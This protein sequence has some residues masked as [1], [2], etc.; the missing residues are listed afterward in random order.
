[1]SLSVVVACLKPVRSS[2]GSCDFFRMAPRVYK[3]P[4]AVAIESVR[5]QPAVVTA[6]ISTDPYNL[7][8]YASRTQAAPW[9][10][11]P[12]VE[13]S[14]TLT[15]E[16]LVHMGPTLAREVLESQR[17]YNLTRRRENID[18]K[19]TGTKSIIRQ[20]ARIMNIGLGKQVVDESDSTK[21]VWCHKGKT[22]LIEEIVQAVKNASEEA[23]GAVYRDSAQRAGLHF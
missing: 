11:Q 23:E 2:F 19:K 22:E 4:A 9:P 1:M 18:V 6:T 8:G 3:R 13:V 10:S 12:I 17:R 20:R 21:V 16:E 5:K 14:E 7:G 15:K